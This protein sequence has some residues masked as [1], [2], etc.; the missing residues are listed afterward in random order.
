MNRKTLEGYQANKRLVERNKQ[1]IEDEQCKDIPVVRGKV[2]GSSHDFP[3]IEQRFSV[4]MEEPME[5]DKSQKRISKWQLEIAKAEQEID[6]VEQFIGGIEDVKTKEI[7][8]YRYIDGM[9]VGE[10]AE[11]IGYS[12]GRVSQ[13]I[14][15]FI[16][17]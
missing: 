9:K 13:I 17:D 4:Q 10:I 5:V 16:K 2:T 1:K 15:K 8:T 3:Y 11:R 6:E 7:F 12:H 14:A